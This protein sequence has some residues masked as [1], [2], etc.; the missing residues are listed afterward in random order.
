MKKFN[1]I[2]LLAGNNDSE[3]IVRIA[4][5]ASIIDQ[6]I[7]LSEKADISADYTVAVLRLLCS[8]LSQ[9]KTEKLVLV[10]ISESYFD[11]IL[12]PVVSS[13][14]DISNNCLV[15]S[16]IEKAVFCIL[17]LVNFAAIAKKA[18]Y[19][20]C[21]SLLQISH[22]Q[23]ALA[24]AFLYGGSN[25]HVSEA[26]FQISRFEHFPCN[27]VALVNITMDYYFYVTTNLTLLYYLVYFAVV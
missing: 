25:K 20:K 6:L 22:V 12:L 10:K 27:D 14:Q 16:D 3:V 8:L 21:C 2:T 4:Q 1:F 17:L 13:K 26:I 7:C 18:Y 9:T 24:T 15:Q 23:K 19:E 11:K 5:D